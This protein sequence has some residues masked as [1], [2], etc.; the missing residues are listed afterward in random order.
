MASKAVKLTTIYNL[1]PGQSVTRNWNN[2]MPANAV[3]YIQ[4]I[5]LESSFTS[6][7]PTV[8]SVEAEVTRVWRKLNRTV[9][10][11]E[12]PDF[13]Y[14]EHEIWFVIK[15]VGSR[16]VNVDVYA[17]IVEAGGPPMTLVNHWFGHIHVKATDDTAE[18]TVTWKPEDGKPRNVIAEIALYHVHEYAQAMITKMVSTEAGTEIAP[19]GIRQRKGVTEVQFQLLVSE[20]G[21]SARWTIY[22]FQ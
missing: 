1:A 11:K 3:W 12:F 16:E 22:E 21:A 14:L 13:P 10:E 7:I 4:A 15:N 8:Q 9:G 17:S 19:T 20:S 6:N 2:A 5:P 18:K